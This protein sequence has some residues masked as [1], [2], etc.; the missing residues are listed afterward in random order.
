MTL[1]AAWVLGIGASS[2]AGFSPGSHL[3]LMRAAALPALRAEVISSPFQSGIGEGDDYDDDDDDDFDEELPLTL[4]NVEKVLDELRPYLM[5]DTPRRRH[6]ETI[7][8]RSDGGNVRVASIDG[9]VR[10]PSAVLA[11][12]SGLVSRWCAS[13]WRA[14]AGR[15]RRR[16]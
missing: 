16:P 9:P 8:L 7:T 1:L 13:S 5:C 14:P 2:V 4:E 15:V 11:S 10:P 12:P 6:T 3:H